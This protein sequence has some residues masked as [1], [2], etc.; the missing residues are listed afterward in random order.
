MCFSKIKEFFTRKTEE[1][2]LP[3]QPRPEE[4][5]PTK[6]PHPEEPR[7][8][9]KTI[10]NVNVAAL[11]NSW[12]TKYHVPAQHWKYWQD[13]HV[14]VTTTYD[15]P[16]GTSSEKNEMRIRPEWANEG[17]L[18]HEF[19]HESYSLLSNKQKADFQTKYSQYL[20]TDPLMVL[21]HS[22]NTYMNTN[23]IEAH[24]EVYRYIGEQMPVNL[25][26]YYPKLLV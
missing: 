9:T 22:K 18:A 16:A 14:I 3:D 24:A 21:L 7:D 11:V 20:T 13:F 23:I 12:L 26:Q 8:N 15:A 2:K 6:L 1:P 4:P 25:Y 5:R 17:V 10:D 19:A